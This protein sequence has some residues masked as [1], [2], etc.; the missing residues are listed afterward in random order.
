M[1]SSMTMPHSTEAEAALLGAM[2]LDS[3]AASLS[4]DPQAFYV[5]FNAAVYSAIQQVQSSGQV[6]DLVTVLDAMSAAGP[7]PD[8][9][10]GLR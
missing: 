6:V 5:P 8:D 3:A 1:S 7:L 2:F 10:L 4:V 9:A